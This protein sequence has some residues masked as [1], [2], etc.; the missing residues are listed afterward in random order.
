VCLSLLEYLQ[1]ASTQ[2]TAGN[3]CPP[4]L[5]HRLG[6]ANYP[7]RPAV[8]NQ[9]R[10]SIIY[11][12]LSALRPSDTGRLPDSFTE[13][14]S[15]G[16]INISTE[17]HADHR[18]RETQVS[19]ESQCK[20]FRERYRGRIADNIFIFTFSVNNNFLPAFYQELGGKSK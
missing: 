17:I 8:L 14:L 20:T 9:R 1:V 2:L 12:L 19:E 7:I 5:Q 15:K 18:S 6:R 3:P 4:T 10:I 11:R 13:G 16:V